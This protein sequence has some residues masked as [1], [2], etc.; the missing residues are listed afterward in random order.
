MKRSQNEAIAADL[1]QKVVFLGGPRQSG[2]TTLAQSLSDDSSYLNYDVADHRALIRERAWDRRKNLLIFDELHKMPQWK[3]W[4]KGVI[5]GERA[6]GVIVTGSARLDTFRKVGDSLAGRFL[7][8]RLHPLD[9]W[10]ASRQLDLS[11]AQSL[12]TILSCSGFPEPFLK[13]SERFY[14]RWAKSHLDIILRQ[15]LIDLEAITD[16]HRVELLVDLLAERVGSPISYRSLAQTLSVS[17]KTVKSWIG[18]LENLY[19]V[20]KVSPFHQSVAR[21][22]QRQPKYYFFDARR[23]QSRVRGRDAQL[24]VRLE[25]I[26]AAALHKHC[27]LMQDQHGEDIEVRFVRRRDGTEIDFVIVCDGQPILQIEVKWSDDQLS[28]AFKKL[29]IEAPALQLV[30]NLAREKTYPFA[31]MVLN[32][33][34][35]LADIDQHLNAALEA[36]PR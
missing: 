16:I 34:D 31:A 30:K 5:D 18:V 26:V 28:P 19:L 4:L 2:K 7:A 24:G 22:I 23:V 17:D 8:H 13:N 1:Q 6:S 33:A 14:K 10:E 32:A 11:A 29:A 25:N 36:T 3:S 21:A 20:F 27:H 9:V 15:D 35:W 12:E